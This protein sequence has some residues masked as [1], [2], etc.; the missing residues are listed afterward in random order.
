MNNTPIDFL[1]LG[2][3][4]FHHRVVIFDK[5]QN[6]IG[7]VDNSRLIELYPN[8]ETLVYLLNGLGVGLTLSAILIL[9]MRKKQNYGRKIGNPLTEP[10]R[11]GGSVEMVQPVEPPLAQ[12]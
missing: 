3:I 6:R 8:S 1:I 9:A 7:F 12:F 5:E 10:L 4:F 2:D 11:I